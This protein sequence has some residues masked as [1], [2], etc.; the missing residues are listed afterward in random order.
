MNE[1]ANLNDS[2]EL[3][4]TVFRGRMFQFRKVVSV[5]MVFGMRGMSMSVFVIATSSCEI[6]YNMTR[7]I[8]VLRS[9]RLPGADPGFQVRGGALKKNCAE[10]REALKM[11]GYFV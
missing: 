11:L 3:L 10:R 8:S 9:A 4:F 5:W 6:L 1:T 7:R 2:T